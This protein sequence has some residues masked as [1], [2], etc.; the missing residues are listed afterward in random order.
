MKPRR[1]QIEGALDVAAADSIYHRLL[2][3]QSRAGGVAL[4]PNQPR[5]DA[6]ALAAI[7][8]AARTIIARGGTFTIEGAP[9]LATTVDRR[10]QA[11]ASRSERSK[12][13]VATAAPPAP[14]DRATRRTLFAT[15]IDSVEDLIR[16]AFRR[17]RMPRGAWSDQIVAMGVDGVAI[18]ALL[19]ALLGLILAFEAA[20]QLRELGATVFVAELVGLSLVREFAPLLTAIV[21]I[22]R[23]G[24]A[25]A[26][27]LS[28][29]SVNQEVDALRTMGISP[30]SFLVSPRVLALAVIQPVLTLLAMFV[31]L[32]ASL[33]TTRVV[34]GITPIQY[35][36]QLVEAVVI[37]DIAYGL[38]KSLAFALATGLIC[39]AVG[40]QT[41][42]SGVAVGQATTRAVVLS[43]FMLVVIDSIFALTS[44]TV[45][46]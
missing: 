21:V 31:G 24:A 6:V 20:E 22:G 18:V 17:A 13:S 15:A 46:M 35:Y 10:L 1:V 8:A 25:V 28:S 44:G 16:V 12:R 33:I 26:S 4:V 11:G 27:E 5:T 32:A 7:V 34:A 42:G 40:L 9:E 2:A 41:R 45:E 43:I 19:S 37:G 30:T 14:P 23:S 38:W 3:A 29:M 39:S 36:N